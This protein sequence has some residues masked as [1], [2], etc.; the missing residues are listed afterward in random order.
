MIG[1]AKMEKM[2]IMAV[3]DHD[4]SYSAN[5]LTKTE[6][7]VLQYMCEDLT[8]KEIAEKM[9]I[10]EKTVTNHITSILKKLNSRSRV[11]A[12]MNA[13]RLGIITIK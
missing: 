9:F 2:K 11:G 13:I 4:E 8:R 12:V 10:S 7:I 6:M 5:P 3:A 1:G